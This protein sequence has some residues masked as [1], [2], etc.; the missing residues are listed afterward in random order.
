[1]GAV[2]RRVCATYFFYFIFLYCVK[3]II[4]REN[5]HRRDLGK[6]A[7]FIPGKILQFLTRMPFTFGVDV[8]GINVRLARKAIRRHNAR[9]NRNFVFAGNPSEKYKNVLHLTLLNMFF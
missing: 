4:T 8:N 9:D 3:A 7:R 5:A 2:Y 6:I 1:V